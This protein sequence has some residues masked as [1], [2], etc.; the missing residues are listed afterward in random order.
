MAAG[1]GTRRAEIVTFLKGLTDGEKLVVLELLSKDPMIRANAPDLARTALNL[2]RSCRNL[3]LV[4]AADAERSSLD[5]E[6]LAH[7]KGCRVER[8]EGAPGA[9]RISDAEQSFA[10][11]EAYIRR[12]IVRG[13]PTQA[14]ED[15]LR[16]LEQKLV[17]LRKAQHRG[18][19]GG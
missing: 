12:M 19:G 4:H 15:R 10:D 7:R 9:W 18:T 13:A 2:R 3:T 17:H 14:A 16:E 1:F 11:Q 5:L 6:F 8:V